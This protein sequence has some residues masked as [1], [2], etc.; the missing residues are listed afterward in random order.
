VPLCGRAECT[1]PTYEAL[2]PPR[3]PAAAIVAHAE[4]LTSVHIWLDANGKVVNAVLG[5]S[6]GNVDLDQS[7][8][9][10]A[11]SWRY[12]PRVC[13]GKA[14]ASEAMVPVK[15]D[16]GPQEEAPANRRRQDALALHRRGR[17][18]SIP[19]REHKRGKGRG[20]IARCSND[21]DPL[22]HAK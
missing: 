1:G 3:Y 21:L 12:A 6:S 4:G 14:V 7:A 2:K 15:F 10:S 19:A 8:I 5:E 9:E 20:S 11:S 16:L 22:Q 18:P 13:D 17:R